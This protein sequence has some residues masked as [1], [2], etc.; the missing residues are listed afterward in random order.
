ML[1]ATFLEESIGL[2]SYT[3]RR[4]KES[5]FFCRA[6][7]IMPVRRLRLAVYNIYMPNITYSHIMASLSSILY[8]LGFLIVLAGVA[9]S[10][11][12]FAR[13]VLY[14][15]SLSLPLPT[16]PDSGSSGGGGDVATRPEAS[17]W[18]RVPYALLCLVGVIACVM[19][20]GIAV[21]MVRSSGDPSA[22]GASSFMAMVPAGLMLYVMIPLY[23]VFVLIRFQ[24]QSRRT[25][26][27]TR[28][29]AEP[30]TD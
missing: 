14:P 28:T 27:T 24:I 17:L 25:R 2:Y 29:E 19:L 22:F 15:Q 6:M 23:V 18:V 8:V 16:R 13:A 9:V 30:H 26:L 10:P 20:V 12:F 21:G 1:V 5:F 7:R 11:L 3:D 4:E